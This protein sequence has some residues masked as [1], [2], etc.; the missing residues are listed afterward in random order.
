MIWSLSKC[1]VDFQRWFFFS[2]PFN[3][4]SFHFPS[5]ILTRV[6]SSSH[7]LPS[8]LFA[9]KDIA[10]SAT[11]FLISAV[12]ISQILPEIMQPHTRFPALYLPLVFH[13]VIHKVIVN[14]T[15]L[16]I[17]FR[18]D[19]TASLLFFSVLAHDNQATALVSSLCPLVLYKR[20]SALIVSEAAAGRLVHKEASVSEVR[21]SDRKISVSFVTFWSKSY[22]SLLWADQRTDKDR[23]CC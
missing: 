2:P 3:Y 18:T 19:V 7:P 20:L 16:N 9:F 23:G 11:F 15:F 21:V 4:D 14:L 12:K 5:W 10:K 6:W 1:P 22:I 8:H 17:L 13:N